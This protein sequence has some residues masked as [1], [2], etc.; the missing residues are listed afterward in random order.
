MKIILSRKGIDSSFSSLVSPI[1]PDGTL[2]WI[3]LPERPQSSPRIPGFEEINT[4]QSSM[5]EVL[6]QLSGQTFDRR[7]RAHLDPDLVESHLKRVRGWKPS[8]GQSGSAERHLRNNGVAEGDLFIFYGSFRQTE[9][10]NGTLRYVR[11]APSLHVIFGWLQIDQRVD[12]ATHEPWPEWMLTHPHVLR[13][14]NETLDAIYFPTPKLTGLALSGSRPGAG[15]FGMLR[16]DLVLSDPNASR[17]RW[18]LPGDFLPGVRPPLTYHSN[19]NR[20][21]SLGDTVALRAASRGQEFV[22]DLDQYPGVK[23]WLEN[24]IFTL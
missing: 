15:T 11:G 2:C 24:Q 20:W 7:R 16:P 9:L 23:S 13:E 17:S 19:E 10:V 6:G 22:L 14:P 3:P 5:G 12:V 21:D 8:F 18:I 4:G 1:L